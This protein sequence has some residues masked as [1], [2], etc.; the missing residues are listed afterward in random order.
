M[1][2]DYT[3]HSKRAV[4][5]D[6]LKI[7]LELSLF[8]KSLTGPLAGIFKLNPDD[9]IRFKKY[10]Q[11][12]GNGKLHTNLKTF[13][14]ALQDYIQRFNNDPLR[15]TQQL[16]AMRRDAE[17]PIIRHLLAR[18]EQLLNIHSGQVTMIIKAR[19]VEERKARE[20]IE[21]G[22]VEAEAWFRHDIWIIGQLGVPGTSWDA[23]K[24]QIWTLSAA[25]QAHRVVLEKMLAKAEIPEIPDDDDLVG[26]LL[27]EWRSVWHS[28]PLQSKR[29]YESTPSIS[30]SLVRAH[31]LIKVTSNIVIALYILQMHSSNSKDSKTGG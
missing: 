18:H 7:A 17:G 26:L 27:F 14:T 30:L 11:I 29:T 23:L 8:L 15:L 13:D 2:L 4:G 1:S 28:L 9:R 31:E 12:L 6:T 21:R 24:A 19:D 3:Q 25:I 20:V 5:A 22:I 10:L 16:Q